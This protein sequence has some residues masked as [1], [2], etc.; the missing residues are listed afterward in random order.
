MN[1]AKKLFYSGNYSS[2]ISDYSSEKNG[3]EYEPEL[4]RFLAISYFELDSFNKSMNL[5][6]E[7]IDRYNQENKKEQFIQTILEKAYYLSQLGNY[8]ESDSLLTFIESEQADLSI[9]LRANVLW[10]RSLYNASWL[11]QINSDQLDKLNSLIASVEDTELLSRIELINAYHSILNW[12]FA[13]AEDLIQKYTEQAIPVYIHDEWVALKTDL[14]L[15]Q[16]STN[17]VDATIDSLIDWYSGNKQNMRANH[18]R[19][20]KAQSL[21]LQDRYEEAITYLDTAIH[22]FRDTR[23]KNYLFDCLKLNI[24][25]LENIGNNK[26]YLEA[27]DVWE[28]EFGNV[29]S[30]HLRIEVLMAR[31]QQLYKTNHVSEAQTVMDSILSISSENK[32][33]KNYLTARTMQIQSMMSSGDFK[34]AQNLI[35]DIDSLAKKNGDVYG[36]YL[37]NLSKG[38]IAFYEHELEQA[39][40][41][42]ERNLVLCITNAYDAGVAYTLNNLGYIYGVLENEEQYRDMSKK[43][44]EYFVSNNNFGSA[45]DVWYNLGVFYKRAGNLEKCNECWLESLN[46]KELIRRN[47]SPENRKKYMNKEIGLYY[48]I[49][50]NYLLLGQNKACYKIGEVSKSKW[51]KEQ[52]SGNDKELPIPDIDSLQRNLPDGM[53]VLELYNHLA[54]ATF[55]IYI[56][57]DTLNVQRNLH[58]DFAIEV[59]DDEHFCTYYL[60]KEG[61]KSLE[62]LQS[63]KD[64]LEVQDFKKI[65]TNYINYYRGLLQ[66]PL[67]DTDLRNQQTK[68]GNK[69]FR[70][71]IEPYFGM[72]KD[73]KDLMIVPDGLFGL[74]PF[75]TLVMN[76]GRYLIEAFNIWYAQS[77]SVW[78]FLNSRTYDNQKSM[79]IIGNPD[80]LSEKAEHTLLRSKNPVY[81]KYFSDSMVNQLNTIR[82]GNLPGSELELQNVSKVFPDASILSGADLTESSI[83]SYSHKHRFKNYRIIHVSSHG[84]FVPG[85][86][87]LTALVLPADEEEDG[88]LNISEIAHLDLPVDLMVLSACETGMG[89]VYYGEGV[90]GLAQACMIAGANSLSVSLWN[91]ADLSTARF[92]EHFYKN[93]NS[94]DMNFIECLNKT[95][96][97]FIHHPPDPLLSTPYYWA[98]F[99]YYGK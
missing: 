24:S 65:L 89:D 11:G 22:Y 20:L 34:T 93:L 10:V 41:D 85:R 42:F 95:K 69:L 98:P 90:V 62:H 31:Y 79:Y 36:M 53:A 96:R 88:F 3:K 54:Y 63:I 92:M 72:L 61:E 4:N 39:K 68:V 58:N 81:S 86:P 77:L 6:S 50:K 51:L 80:Y 48:I 64:K 74:I 35:S 32:L 7:L 66:E 83:K 87:D 17:N 21:N 46:Y 76:D 45:S 19:F 59:L 13:R 70:L 43:A 37:V 18:Y 73:K 82:W 28:K 12:R 26:A 84:I 47:S 56:D 49:Q 52:L 30:P 33:Y 97:D 40:T 38:T 27:L 99:I 57:Q 94:N 75:E 55:G 78:N 1:N 29:S 67:P 14:L 71:F 8:A 9:D 60:S 16:K 25:A 91:I 44:L 2:L 15:E 5:F 23:L